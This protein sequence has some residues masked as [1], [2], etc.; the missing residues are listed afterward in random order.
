MKCLILQPG[1]QLTEAKLTLLIPCFNESQ[2]L[3]RA[4]DELQS[5]QSSNSEL[6][7]KIL[8]INDGSTDD[9][10]N[11]IL[12][13]PLKSTV[14]TLPENLGKGGAV[15]QG[16][17]LVS[18]ELVLVMDVDISTS[19]NCIPFFLEAMSSGS[20]DL[21]VGN[22]F[23]PLS[24]VHRPI[25]RSISSYLFYFIIHAVG[26]FRT[27]DTQCGFKLYKTQIAQQLFKKLRLLRYS[28]DLEIIM[29]AEKNCSILELPVNWMDRGGSKVRIL[30]DGFRMVSDLLELK[31]RRGL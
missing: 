19:L 12:K 7:V 6:N 14:L 11:L 28:F 8:F 29:R 10:E 18:T 31:Y 25:T 9:T 5:W 13:H 23:H 3:P 30:S 2:R 17:K 24:R 20:Y 4:L 1:T 26:G 27:N 16:V 22:R 15:A 21:I